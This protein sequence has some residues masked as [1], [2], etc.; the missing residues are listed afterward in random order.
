MDEEEYEILTCNNCGLSWNVNEMEFFPDPNS[1]DFSLCT[2]CYFEVLDG[3]LEEANEYN[4]T[5]DWR[6]EDKKWKN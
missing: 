5:I 6:I 3:I 1:D 2:D 4:P